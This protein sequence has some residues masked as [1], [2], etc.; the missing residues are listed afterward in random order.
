M[1]PPL[2]LTFAAFNLCPLDDLKVVIIGQDPY[3]DNGQAEGLCF[4]VPKGIRPPSS[5]GNIYK[6]LG[7][8]IAGFKRPTHGHLVEW[9]KQ[10]ILLLNTGL[11]VQAH[12]A[13]SHKG[14]VRTV[15]FVLCA[16]FYQDGFALRGGKY[17][18]MLSSKQLIV[19]QKELFSCCGESMH[20]TKRSC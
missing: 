13:N 17:L 16:R 4:S 11:T 10:G 14:K 2:P 20:R 19:R 9:A 7:T 15:F 6:E 3:H 5:L 12:K 8:D 18:L 1:F